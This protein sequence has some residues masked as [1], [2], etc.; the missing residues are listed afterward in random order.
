[1]GW[2]SRGSL[3]VCVIERRVQQLVKVLIDIFMYYN[4]DQTSGAFPELLEDF[5]IR[6]PRFPIHLVRPW[7]F[8]RA[9]SPASCKKEE[10]DSLRGCP[11]IAADTVH[12][13]EPNPSASGSALFRVKLEY[14]F[15]SSPATRPLLLLFNSSSVERLT[16]CHTYGLDLSIRKLLFELWPDYGIP[17]GA[18]CLPEQSS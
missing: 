7:T 6:K 14:L 1:V 13:D 2:I 18:S 12:K 8:D 3:G 10:D 17:T 9:P 15:E 5:W 4:P 16:L 11:R